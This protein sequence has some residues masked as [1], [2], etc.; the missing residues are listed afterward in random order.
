[1]L[2]LDSRSARAAWTVFLV[3][4]SLLVLYFIRRVLLVFV[5]AI[6][7]AYLISPVVNLVD[8]FLSR[9]VS[10]T[11]ALAAVYVA[12]I[13][14]LILLGIL[15][16]TQVSQEAASLA[17]RFPDLVKKLE[18]RLETP[19][20]AWFELVRGHLLNLLREGLQTLAK[21]AGPVLQ[22]VIARAISF[23]SGAI[24]VILVPILAF[25]FL[26]DGKELRTSILGMVS[27]DRRAMLEDILAD[28]N[29]LLGQFMRALV[30]LSVATLTA[31]G[32]FFTLLGV[33]YSLLLA[34][35]AGV[36]EFIPVVGPLAAVVII[37]LVAVFSGFG[38]VVLILA[39]VAGY[40][41][42]Q[43]YILSPHLMSA[44]VALHPLLVIFGALAGEELAGIPGMF[45]SVPVLAILRVLYVRIQKARATT[46]SHSAPVRL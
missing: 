42:F 8:R 30:L 20:P 11:W 17:T 1:M 44:G 12:L 7:F 24:V 39:F 45:L 4:L 36:L 21:V 25:F 26:K 29:Q 13:A 28:V 18:T 10:R 2:G 35:I 41:I 33:P 31:Y 32:L 34:S 9:R 37:V 40:R 43:D 5:L 38:H 6:L 3:A 23:L 46:G 19:G 27:G 22:T 16:G 15:I 14:V